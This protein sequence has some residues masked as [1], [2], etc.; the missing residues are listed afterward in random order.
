MKILFAD[1]VDEQRLERLRD[2]GHECT[3]TPTLSADTLPD[4]V[5]DAEV[6]VVRSTKVTDATISAGANLGLIVRA[7]AGTDN[8]DKAAAARGGVYVCNVPGKNAIAVAE[9]TM[10]LLLAIDR[11]IADNVRDL[12][13]GV[14]N[15]SLYTKAD[16]LAGKKLAIVGLGDIGLAVAER[17]KAF[18]LLVS[19]V[20]KDGRSAAVLQQIRSIGIR[21]VDDLPTLL[22]DADIVS[23]HVPKAEGT[24]GLV[25]AEFL[26]AVPDGAI[27]LN[28]SRGDIVDE[29][30]LLEALNHRGMRA[31]LDVYADEPSSGSDT[32]TSELAK[33]PA[34]VGTHHI[35][36]STQQAQ[37][38][39]ADGTI[40]VIEHYAKGDIINC[41]N[42]AG[43]P[44]G[45]HCVVIRHEDRV[46][47]LAQI[48]AVMRAHGLNVQ[49]MSNQVFAHDGAA[50]ATIHIG[51]RDHQHETDA[52]LL[53]ELHAIDEVI[54]AS[55]SE[56]G[57]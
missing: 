36:A 54:S 19:A 44:T 6:L 50:V 10:G 37:A 14:W 26:K 41:V 13:D 22:A 33:H 23:I 17:A 7:G 11:N 57:S 3:V 45:S 53:N 30:A 52:S 20:R 29:S 55:F 9:L 56:S 27:V 35:G 31:G 42:L 18:G 38:A 32:F 5:G 48:F 4:E 47:V 24:A 28:T 39:V 51:G 25:D 49:Q 15:K 1:A 34:V 40:E 16:G 8:I 21:L 12:R 46:G 2:A 43:D